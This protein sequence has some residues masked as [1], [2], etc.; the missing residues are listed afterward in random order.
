[1][2]ENHQSVNKRPYGPAQS[3]HRSTTVAAP[4]RIVATMT[5]IPSRIDLI[6]PVIEACQ[7][8]TVPLQHIEINIPLYCV[9]T[10]AAYHLPG[11]LE[12]M[13]GVKIF[14]T[15]DYGPIT[16]VAPTLIRYCQDPKTYIWS[17]DD[18]C[19]YPS[20]QLEL[21]CTAHDPNKRR[22]LTRYGGQL[23]SDGTVNFWHG[24][25]EVTLF[26]GFGGVLYPPGCIGEDFQEFLSVTSENIDCR[27]ND[28]IVLSMYFSARGVPIYLYNRPSV[29]TPYMVSGW[30][31]HAS[32]R[33][34]L[35]NT[36]HSENYKRISTFVKSLNKP[37]ASPTNFP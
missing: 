13:D 25:G 3:L 1:M 23:G 30:L 17:V 15:E 22:I 31:P 10:A 32:D 4:Q 9:R 19:A 21:L 37:T 24:V 14:R 33:E 20:N 36:N 11:W 29:E 12:S 2:Q 6:R 28:D 8:Q 34:A 26:E 7:S 16:K 27:K 18:D 5:T 35:I